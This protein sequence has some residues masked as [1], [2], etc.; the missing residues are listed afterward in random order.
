[1]RRL[2]PLL[3]LGLAAPAAARVSWSTPGSYRFR[4]HHLTDVPLDEQGTTTGQNVWGSHRLRIDP[5]IETG[6][7]RVHIQLDV[8]T[9]QTFGDTNGIGAG[10]VERR[11]GDPERSSAGWTTV[12]PRMLW[13]DWQW[14][15]GYLQAGQL[16]AHFGT[17]LLDHDG[18]DRGVG[19]VERFGDVWAGD[20]VDR[21]L[22]AVRPLAPVYLREA[23]EL[24]L[25]VGID[26]VWQDDEASLLSDDFAWRL[27]GML[28]YP[29]EEVEAGVYIVHRRQTDR[30]DD[31]LV[32]T[33]FDAFGRVVHS[34]YR[35]GADLKVEG[36]AVLVTGRTNRQRAA[37]S[38]EESDL[39]Q[40][41]W[42]LNGELAWR[43]PRV[44][45]GLELGYASGDSDPADAE[46]RTFTFDRGHTVGLVLFPEVLRLVSLR[47][48]ERLA[49]PTRVGRPPGGA[50]TLP[51]DGAVSNAFY[52]M[53]GLTWR[54]GRWRLSTAALIA[55][56]AEPFLDPYR[57]LEAG[58]TG[59][60]HRDQPASRY[61]GTEA[62]AGAHYTLSI[63]GVTDA[64][65]FGVQG[66]VLVPGE[67]LEGAVDDDL[68]F[69]VLG[70][71]D[72]RWR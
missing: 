8:L 32:S 64:L 7:V 41:G 27:F 18:I 1:M 30:D 20:L 66:G 56:A 50:D 60:S 65:E 54:P 39:L 59:R 55:W 25:A 4:V 11:D 68:V 16:G 6:P 22:V 62:M 53:P 21:L 26:N 67:A 45:A 63:L 15:W 42:S 37:S 12:E 47:A 70:R 46:L 34:L 58:G 61:Y 38:G 35:H 23:R 9:G 33:A 72:L 17:G 40:L 36:E 5:T 10:F 13:V 71:V 48:A 29:G 24:V 57:T 43:C 14:D 28:L 19:E 3:L 69:K 44:A 31:S 2:I 49:D 51:T 52:V